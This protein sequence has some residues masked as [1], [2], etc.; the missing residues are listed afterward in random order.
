MRVFV[1]KYYEK[2]K[3]IA[4]KCSHSCCIG[5]EIDVDPDTRARHE[6]SDHALSGELIGSLSEQ[7]GISYIELTCDGRC[8]FLDSSGLCRI[9]SEIGEDHTSRICREHP[10]FYHR[11][12]D[13]VE[14][15]IGAVC[16]EAARIILDSDDYDSFTECERE[17]HTPPSGG[18]AE[19]LSHRENIYR[20]LRS[21]DSMRGAIAEI[22]D[23]YGIEQREL[24]CADI[25]ELI[26]EMELLDES[27]RELLTSP[28][29]DCPPWAEAYARRFFAYLIYR[30]L[31][32]CE[33]EDMIPSRVAMAILLTFIYIGALFGE[34]SVSRAVEC[35]RLI[36]EEI[37]YSEDNT[38]TL[39]FQLYTTI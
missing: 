38:D 14:C 27:H 31:G 12:A 17:D 25:L 18:C 34:G 9:I 10:R 2:F 23:V 5:W 28:S 33:S 13:R 36:S 26:S 7:D 11:I 19:V 24:F 39:T 35:A 16:E 6:C 15:G 32:S 29:E 4:E 21:H 3:C 37:E 20:I 1:P 8:P 22:C 30:H